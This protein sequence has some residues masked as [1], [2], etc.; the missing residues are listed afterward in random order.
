MSEGDEV[1]LSPIEQIYDRNVAAEK[2]K[3]GTKYELLTA[4]VFQVLDA[5]AAVEHDV[6]LRGD[7]KTTVHQ[8]D[9]H[10]IRGDTTKR[11]IVECR[12]KT[13]DHKVDLDEARSF[14]T[15]TRHL[16][17]DGIMV[18]TNGFTAGAVSLANDEGLRL[19]NLRAFLPSDHDGRL[20]AI[21]T[22]IRAVMPELDAVRVE[23]PDADG[24]DFNE[25]NHEVSI[26]ASVVSGS[27][28]ATLRDLLGSLMDAP[29]EGDLPDRQQTASQDFDPPVILDADG[30]RIEVSSLQVDYH[31]EVGEVSF[32]IDAG[33]QVAE[34]ILRSLD[35]AINRVFWSADL[36]RYIVAPTGLVVGR[37]DPRGRPMSS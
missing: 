20:M 25:G 18:T 28:A 34:L 23:M 29:F 1:G 30:H 16:R 2:L 7:G 36:Q 19:M 11:V 22:T 3:H 14:A 4:L 33:N 6:K 9:V 13:D 12:D 21:E 26:D 27:P 24:S 10:I 31:I 32:R 15:V 5:D 8:I 17:A 35:G 37:A